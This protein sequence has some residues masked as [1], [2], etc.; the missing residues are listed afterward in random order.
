MNQMKKV[1][2]MQPMCEMQHMQ[3]VPHLREINRKKKRIPVQKRKRLI[4]IRISQH[5]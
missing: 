3:L 5:R 4:F 1:Y 2:H